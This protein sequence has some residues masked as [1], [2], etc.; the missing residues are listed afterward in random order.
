MRVI[1][2]GV[3]TGSILSLSGLALVAMAGPACS[4]GRV[5][6]CGESIR[7]PA[8]R[9]TFTRASPA[10][11]S[12]CQA[13]GSKVAWP[14]I[15]LLGETTTVTLTLRGVC[16][17]E[18][19]PVHLVLLMDGSASMRGNPNRLMKD[20]AIKLID[21]LFLD[22]P[23]LVRVGVVTFSA[24]AETLCDLTDDVERVKGCVARVDAIGESAIDT[25]IGEGLKVLDR[26]RDGVGD[27]PA[28]FL[29]VFSDSA[30]NRRCPEAVAA[31]KQA[32][33]R[34]V[35]LLAVCPSAKCDTGCMKQIWPDLAGI[36]NVDYPFSMIQWDV[37]CS[38]FI[39]VKI[40][41]AIITDTL[42]ANMAYVAGS[43]VPPST[44]GADSRTLVWRAA[45]LTVDGITITYKVR[46]LQVG[47][48]ATS[49]STVAAL[50]DNRGSDPI[51][52]TFPVPW[53]T[54]LQP[55]PIATIS[56][57]LVP[58]LTPPPTATPTPGSHPGRIVMPLLL[59]N[60]GAP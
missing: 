33:A 57:P 27:A 58:T 15:L 48:R 23:P 22:L 47:Y 32:E 12:N 18:W 13:D 25:G 8:E 11:S 10:S 28:E 46:P 17:Y 53:I 35:G 44:V 37:G 14:G 40:D 24:T 34:G 42:P 16:A 54:A 39:V 60:S 36:G 52:T 43:A 56:D 2:A 19:P 38:R 50:W 3:V 45:S 55:Y 41:H 49:E 51:T 59:Y 7:P 6:A 5:P 9:F 30:N 20:A 4:A 31:A 21:R 29:I 26:G 1:I